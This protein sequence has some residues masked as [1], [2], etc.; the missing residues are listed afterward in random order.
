VPRL[1]QSRNGS[2]G[3]AVPRHALAYSLLVLLSLGCGSSESGDRATNGGRSAG[4]RSSSAGGPSAGGHASGSAGTGGGNSHAGS[5][6][7]A[8][9]GESGTSGA[10]SGGNDDGGSGG[11]S[12]DQ[13]GRDTGGS[14]GASGSGG[15]AGTGATAGNGGMSGSGG[16]GTCT[17]TTVV[18]LAAGG[19][20]VCAVFYSGKIKCWGYNLDGELGY[21]NTENVGDDELP[22]AIGYVSLSDDPGVTVRELSIGNTHACA[23]LSDGTVNCWGRAVFGV[24]GRG[25]DESIGDDELPSDVAP[26][27][28]ITTPGLSVEQIS[29]GGSHTCALLSNGTI[30]CWGDNDYR[31]LGRDD[32]QDL[33]DDELPSDVAPVSVSTTPG[34]TVTQ[35]SAGFKH[36]CALLSDGTVKCWGANGSGQLA[37]GTPN[38]LADEQLPSEVEPIAITTAADV[39]AV[40]IRAGYDS[41]CVLLSDG[42]VKCWGNAPAELVGTGETGPVLDPSS[43]G[44]IEVTEESGLLV[45]DL[46]TGPAHVCARLADGSAA[47]WGTSEYGA[48]GYGHIEP[49]GDDEL[50]SSAGPVSV[51]TT[52]GLTVTQL[53]AGSDLT[54]ALLSDHSVKCWGDNRLGGLG[55]GKDDG[56]A[57]GDDELPSTVGPVELL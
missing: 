33:G 45:T 28:V 23:L 55:N 38:N 30:Q 26:V 17:A 14:G 37:R 11:E 19:G 1:E 10:S 40:A 31:Q 18:A 46:A 25:N 52:P 44:P 6:G 36:T 35:I 48:L 29:A 43:V 2:D 54:C 47:C 27:S 34:V 12:G 57:V 24:L 13:G 16:C 39:T 49:I 22:S 41:T 4:G 56:F 5:G 15:T 3:N 42:T 7:R 51:T 53:A 32:T 9:G 21:G 8:N 50:P 20:S